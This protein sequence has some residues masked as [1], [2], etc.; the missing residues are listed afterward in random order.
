MKGKALMHLDG[1]H[2]YVWV[3][4]HDDG[5]TRLTFAERDGDNLMLHARGDDEEPCERCEAL[6]KGSA[7]RYVSR[8]IDPLPDDP[9]ET[10]FTVAC[11]VG[12]IDEG[13]VPVEKQP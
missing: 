8:Q 4:L 12:E 13:V 9:K 3:Y 2:F 5:T 1:C 6:R 7:A 10:F 11:L